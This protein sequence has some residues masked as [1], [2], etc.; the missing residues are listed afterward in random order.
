MINNL[1]HGRLSPMQHD[2]LTALLL[3]LSACSEGLS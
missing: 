3:H 2:A 1:H